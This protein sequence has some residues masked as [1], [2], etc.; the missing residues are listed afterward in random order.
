MAGLGPGSKEAIAAPQRSPCG[1]RR[2]AHGCPLVWAHYGSSIAAGGWSPAPRDLLLTAA[3]PYHE[4]INRS[5]KAG[6]ALMRILNQG[7]H[8]LNAPALSPVSAPGQEFA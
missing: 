4:W 2:Q 6:H 3:R 5:K 1:R 7:M 8:I